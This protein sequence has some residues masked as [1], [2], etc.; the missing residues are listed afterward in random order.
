MTLAIL[1]IVGVTGAALGIGAY[2]V[3]VARTT[4]DLFVASRVVTPWSRWTTHWVY[5]TPGTSVT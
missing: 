5:P 4:S 2:G 1:A 3:R